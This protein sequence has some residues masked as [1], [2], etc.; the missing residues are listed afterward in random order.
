VYLINKIIGV[1]LIMNNDNNL[2][3]IEKAEEFLNEIN[4][5][6][7]VLEEVKD[8]FEKELEDF[9]TDR[10]NMENEIKKSTEELKS[11]LKENEME[12]ITQMREK[13][14]ESLLISREVANEAGNQKVVKNIDSILDGMEAART[15]E[16]LKEKRFFYNNGKTK[17]SLKDLNQLR[18]NARRKLS[19]SKTYKFRDII[20]LTDILHDALP[21]DYKSYTNTFLYAFYTLIMHSRLPN[22]AIFV[23]TLILNIG[24]LKNPK[25][26]INDET[27]KSIISVID[28]SKSI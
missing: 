4:G 10:I 12:S 6:S 7:E 5:E 16:I 20:D 15:L 24:Y 17:P 14:K 21:D 1:E 22:I 18:K 25:I 9:E 27:T 2:E 28:F 11:Y 23:S 26:E 3:G 13:M 8:D 19:V